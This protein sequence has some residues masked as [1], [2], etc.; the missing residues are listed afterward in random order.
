MMAV[1]AADDERM[2]AAAVGVGVAVAAA[3]PAGAA[4]AGVEAVAGAVAVAVAVAVV[5]AAFVESPPLSVCSSDASPLLD[6]PP[7]GTTKVMGT[8]RWPLR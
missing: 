4:G 5:V 1:A 6:A 8:S 3:G 2:E 7:P